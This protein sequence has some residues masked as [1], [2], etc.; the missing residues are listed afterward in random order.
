MKE[1]KVK[2]KELVTLLQQNE[3][4]KKETIIDHKLKEQAVAI[5]L[6]ISSLVRLFAQQ[7][8]CSSIVV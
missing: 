4:Q 5:A 6:A 1:M 2:L 3:A 7:V 8:L